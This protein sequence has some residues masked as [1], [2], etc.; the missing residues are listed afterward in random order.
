MAGM[1]DAVDGKITLE[2]LV[3]GAVALFRS[4]L[5]PFTE[6]APIDGACVVHVYSPTSCEIKGMVSGGMGAGKMI[7]GYRTVCRMMAEQGYTGVRLEVFDNK[8]G[9]RVWVDGKTHRRAPCTV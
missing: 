9:S 2:W 7:S 3:R 6:P 1:P 5:E 8:G 4:H